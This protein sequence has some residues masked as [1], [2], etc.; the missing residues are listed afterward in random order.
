[1]ARVNERLGGRC[2]FV[3]VCV[4]EDD[5]VDGGVAEEE[6]RRVPEGGEDI[7]TLESWFKPCQDVEADSVNPGTD[8]DLETEANVG[9]GGTGGT[10]PSPPLSSPGPASSP[11]VKIG[12]VSPDESKLFQGSNGRPAP[13]FPLRT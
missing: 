10:A 9:N 3:C 2:T 13:T 12:D 8:S 6:Y 7:K 4:C 5:E 11:I 1:M